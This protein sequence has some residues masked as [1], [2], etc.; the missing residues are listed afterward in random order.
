MDGIIASDFSLEKDDWRGYNL[1]GN[2]INNYRKR[3]SSAT[4]YFVLKDKNGKIMG[5]NNCCAY[6]LFPAQTDGF[7]CG[8][9]MNISDCETVN[10]SVDF[11]I[12]NIL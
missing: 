1:T 5:G 7:E 8:F 9:R 6:D 12:R 4:I 2:V 11:Y 3:V 10:H